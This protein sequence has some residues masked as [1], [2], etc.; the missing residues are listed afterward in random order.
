MC[1]C[2]VGLVAT[3]GNFDVLSSIFH[4]RGKYF[5]YN[6]LSLIVL[7]FPFFRLT[8]FFGLFLSA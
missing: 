5:L 3:S 2:F 7:G 1:F 6:T 8:V 4:R